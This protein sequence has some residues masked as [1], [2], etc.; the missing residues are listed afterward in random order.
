MRELLLKEVIVATVTLSVKYLE[1][2][3]LIGK[4]PAIKIIIALIVFGILLAFVRIENV[5]DIFQSENGHY[6][7]IYNEEVT[8]KEARLKC[9]NV[10]GHLVT[11]EDANEQKIVS[12]IA[13]GEVCW[14]G[15]QKDENAGWSWITGEKVETFFWDKDEPN[16]NN[17][18]EYVM[19]MH[20]GG[21]WNDASEEYPYSDEEG[22]PIRGLF[23][24]C[25][26]EYKVVLIIGVGENNFSV[27]IWR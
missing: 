22:K 8:W 12:R 15:A 27:G 20:P 16:N 6:Y 1:K 4:K 19:T 10:G 5:S 18:E 7:R 11:I 13:G 3:D 25:E 17:G 9:E 21:G 26:W 23:Y 14:I 2:N 24:I